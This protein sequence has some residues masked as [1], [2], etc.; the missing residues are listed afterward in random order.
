MF[1]C[2]KCRQPSNGEPHKQG[3]GSG[4]NRSI[5]LY[6]DTCWREQVEKRL[7][8]LREYH[9]ARAANP[10]C[11][12]CRQ[13]VKGPETNEGY[14]CA[15]CRSWRD[16]ALVL[17]RA[18]PKAAQY[19]AACELRE[20]EGRAARDAAAAKAAETRQP[21]LP[22]QAGDHEARMARMEKLLNKLAADL[23]VS[24]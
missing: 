21:S 8:G 6:C 7:V 22:S 15:S 17:I 12:Y 11:P 5:Y 18:A 13:P 2:N 20:A 23:G 24:A 3:V 19:I 9:A 10:V 1:T 4:P 14:V 16:Y